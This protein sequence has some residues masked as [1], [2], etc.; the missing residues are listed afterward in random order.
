MLRV[1]AHCDAVTA[2]MGRSGG[3]ASCRTVPR[4]AQDACLVTGGTGKIALPLARYHDVSAEPRGREEGP[5]HCQTR[6]VP[7]NALSACA[8]AALD[9]VA[10]PVTV[11]ATATVTVTVTATATATVQEPG[12][13]EVR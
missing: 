11:A 10:D 4:R 13:V 5:A 6:H 3:P 8:V 7:M 2:W 1:P 9:P 12:R